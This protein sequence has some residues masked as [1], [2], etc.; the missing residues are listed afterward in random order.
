MNTLELQQ[1]TAIEAGGCAENTAISMVIGAGIGFLF[2]GPAGAIIGM[3]R[4][5][6]TSVGTCMLTYDW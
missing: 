5:A 1:M 4:A 2:G 6:V 3:G